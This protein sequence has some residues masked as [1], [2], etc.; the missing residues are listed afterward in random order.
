MKEKFKNWESERE[1]EKKRNK[2]ESRKKK[3][4]KKYNWRK[5]DKYPYT[6]AA[7]LFI[8]SLP[9]ASLR[10]RYKTNGAS[11]ELDYIASCFKTERRQSDYS[12]N[13]KF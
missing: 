13:C 7:Y 2:K 11:T 4:R 8:N 9:L 1:R 5:K 3:K 10:E 12:Q 6:Q